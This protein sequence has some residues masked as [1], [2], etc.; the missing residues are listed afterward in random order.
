LS[1]TR[2]G[3]PCRSPAESRRRPGRRRERRRKGRAGI[4]GSAFAATQGRGG[5][6]TSRRCRTSRYP[7]HSSGRRV[8]PSAGR[9]RRA[10]PSTV[11]PGRRGRGQTVR[12]ATWNVN[13][14]KARLDKVSQENP[15]VP[16]ASAA[17]H[18]AQGGGANLNSL[19][20][21]ARGG[22][23][24]NDLGDH[25]RAFPDF[26]CHRGCRHGLTAPSCGRAAATL[27][28]RSR[29]MASSAN[30]RRRLPSQ[31]FRMVSASTLPTPSARRTA[32]LMSPSA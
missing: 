7:E 25:I 31:F 4:I 2:A 18:D 30:T 23:V 27:V 24:T 9:V 29:P 10:M 22:E 13:S 3:G 26:A 6:R 14:L 19:C 21:V 16:G 12:I 32:F 17:A 11:P 20:D 1:G 15:G 8:T 28:C 5:A